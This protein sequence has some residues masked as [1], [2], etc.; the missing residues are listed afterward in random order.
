MNPEIT[1]KD[2][3]TGQITVRE[4]TDEEYEEYKAQNA[5]LTGVYDD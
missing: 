1:I 4:M 2:V 3:L 5:H